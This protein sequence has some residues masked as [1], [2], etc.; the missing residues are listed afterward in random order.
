MN[1]RTHTPDSPANRA[2]EAELLAQYRALPGQDA[3]Q[4]AELVGMGNSLQLWID[5]EGRTHVFGFATWGPAGVGSHPYLAATFGKPGQ[6]D[7]QPKAQADALAF[8]ANET[9][10][11]V[12]REHG[13]SRYTAAATLSR[14]FAVSTSRTLIGGE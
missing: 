8:A 5:L 2:A 4:I 7:E 6:W 14:A 9:F 1:A 12:G 10:A 13:L 11:A 3:M